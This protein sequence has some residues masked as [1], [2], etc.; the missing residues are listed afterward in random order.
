LKHFAVDVTLSRRSAC[1][2]RHSRWHLSDVRA[3]VFLSQR[4]WTP[5]VIVRNLTDKWHARSAVDN[6]CC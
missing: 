1:R 5:Q 4:D 6:G 2:D 3:G